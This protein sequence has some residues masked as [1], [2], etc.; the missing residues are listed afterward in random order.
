MKLPQKLSVA[1]LLW[2]LILCAGVYV[3]LFVLLKNLL[4]SLL[5]FLLFFVFALFLL[6]STYILLFLR[7]FR[8]HIKDRILYIKSGLIFK[9][10]KRFLLSRMVCIKTLS[11]P[12]LRLLKLKFLLITFEGSIYILPPV[13]ADFAKEIFDN[14]IERQGYEE[15]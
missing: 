6:L 14:T 2:T 5:P 8:F 7:S 4:P 10:D 15:V 1:V 11:T 9:R 3:S 13:S 12:F